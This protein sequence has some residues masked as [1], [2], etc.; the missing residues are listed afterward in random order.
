MSVK[1]ISKIIIAGPCAVESRDQIISLAHKMKKRNIGIVRGSWWKPRTKPG[2]DGVGIQAAPWAA[3]MTRL[4][5]TV[6]TE[7]MLPIHVTQVIDGITAN[8]GDPAQILFWIGSRNQNHHT[9]RE[10]ARRIKD[11]APNSVK[12]LIK[13]QPWLDQDHWMG[14]IDHVT[15]AGLPAERLILCHR[16][17]APS[18]WDN[19][20]GLRNL[21]DWEMTMRVREKT[22]LPMLVD[23]SHIGGSVPNVF[24]VVNEA[25]L[26]NFDGIM[27]EVHPNPNKAKTDKRQQLNIAEF[28]DLLKVI[29]NE[30]K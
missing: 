26:I 8:Q 22:G 23:L 29:K 6:A 28:D 12:L 4:G 5:I 7:V 25:K 20:N 24:R 21:P 13:N 15:N 17:F 19:P 14:I 9:Q 18:N 30:G 16:G 10:I 3:E 27:V 11:E 1:S 2:F